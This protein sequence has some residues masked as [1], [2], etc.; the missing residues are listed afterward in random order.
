MRVLFEPKHFALKTNNVYD[1]QM[2]D[3][4]SRTGAGGT[5]NQQHEHLERAR[6]LHPIF[7][8]ESTSYGQFQVLG[9]NY[10]KAGYASVGAFE[11]AMQASAKNQLHAF[12]NFVKN[13]PSLHEAMRDRDWEGIAKIYNGPGWRRRN[14]FYAQN[15]LDY[16]HACQS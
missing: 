4:N 5:F 3:A 12:V 16:F 15:L 11:V 2:G 1:A 6:R 13:S 8:P 7:A 10:A 9:A 14:P